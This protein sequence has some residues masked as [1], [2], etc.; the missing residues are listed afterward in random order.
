M[1]IKINCTIGNNDL[2]LYQYI[3]LYYIHVNRQIG[4]DFW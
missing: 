1:I 2:Y 4:S 3:I